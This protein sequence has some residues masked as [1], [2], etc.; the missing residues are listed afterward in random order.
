MVLSVYCTF[1]A[2][3]GQMETLFVPWQDKCIS[4][5][6]E[7]E[8]NL[9]THKD[10]YLAVFHQEGVSNARTVVIQDQEENELI[11]SN[12]RMEAWSVLIALGI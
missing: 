8:R 1:T 12:K 5:L 4:I 3:K 11:R 7:P 10:A 2:P 9:L 6:F